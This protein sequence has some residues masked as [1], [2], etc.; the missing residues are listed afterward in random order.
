MTNSQAH[1]MS[2]AVQPD[3]NVTI[4]RNISEARKALGWKQ[5]ELAER[6]GLSRSSVAKIE[7]F[8][9]KGVPSPTLDRIAE[10]LGVPAFMLMLRKDDWK[11]LVDVVLAS[12]RGTAR[13][14]VEVYL[15]SEDRISVEEV[16]R[17]QAA[18]ASPFK[19]ERRVAVAETNTVVERILG[20][21][22]RERGNPCD[23]VRKSMTAATG[24]AT[25][26]SPNDPIVGGLI[27]TIFSTYR[28]PPW[29]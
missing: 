6:A 29:N 25:A 18:L 23:G 5:L 2:H 7:S 19:K 11:T 22:A 13:E 24:M 16:E 21:E 4:G 3:I 8:N 20:L 17:I 15:R 26:A 28:L 12:G 9:G 1:L 27:A 14:R 10:A